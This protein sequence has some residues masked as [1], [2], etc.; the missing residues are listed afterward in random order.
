MI[1]LP[2]YTYNLLFLRTDGEQ[3]LVEHV[4]EKDAREHLALFGVGGADIYRRI[5][6]YEQ[7]WLTQTSRHLDTVVFPA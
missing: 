7:D 6:L 5:D 4:T 2:R 3:E 1:T